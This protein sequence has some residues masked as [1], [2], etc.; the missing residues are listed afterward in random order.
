MAESKSYWVRFFAE[1]SPLHLL[2]NPRVMNRFT[3]GH[4]V[5]IYYLY[6]KHYIDFI[7]VGSSQSWL[8]IT[9][10]IFEPHHEK[11][12]ILPMRKQRCRSAVQ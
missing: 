2:T 9:G 11:T 10:V 3:F 5:V 12:G 6:I 8:W 1:S 7:C 4:G